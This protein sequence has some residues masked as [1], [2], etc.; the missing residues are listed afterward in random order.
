MKLELSDMPEKIE[1]CTSGHFT[2]KAILFILFDLSRP[3]TFHDDDGKELHV[4]SLYK[5]A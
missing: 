3:R 1:M 5:E 4:P 2:S